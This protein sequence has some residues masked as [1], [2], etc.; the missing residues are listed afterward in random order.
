SLERRARF[1]LFEGA[2]LIEGDL[3]PNGLYHS[4]LTEQMDPE[5]RVFC[6]EDEIGPVFAYSRAPSE[7]ADDVGGLATTPPSQQPL[8]PFA[9]A[10]PI[11]D[12]HLGVL[13]EAASLT[14]WHLRHK[15]CAKS[16]GRTVNEQAGWRR[17]C[18]QSGTMHFP[19]TDPV[20]IMSV[21][22]RKSGDILLGRQSRF[23]PGMFSC[24]AGFVE[25]GE[26]LEDAV[27]REVLEEAGVPLG[28]V[29][30]RC[31]Q[32]WP[33]PSTLMMAFEGEALSRELT[34]DEEELVEAK[35][36]SRAEIRQMGMNPRDGNHDTIPPKLAIARSLL[37]DYLMREE[38]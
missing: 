11:L 9:E 37:D 26:T 17:S 28:D 16:G 3:E 38:L 33:F 34:L 32:P 6:G 13:A 36:F 30:Y 22:D 20:V 5:T 23:P 19:R 15:F 10:L 7:P 18:P 1:I 4:R 25:S 27:R 29:T 2:A 31:S 12:H 24:L 8:R 14:G 35:W 21:V